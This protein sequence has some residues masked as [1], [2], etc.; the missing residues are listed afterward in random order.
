MQG[1][2]DLVH[3]Q[4]ALLRAR[5][6]LRK[7][8]PGELIRPTSPS[9]L[10]GAPPAPAVVARLDRIAVSVRRAS[11]YG[12]FRPTCLVRAIALED[13]AHRTGIDDSVVRVGVR[14]HSGVFEAHAWLELQGLVV[15]DTAD[16]VA[17]FT[18]LE[19]FSSLVGSER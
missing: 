13:L 7:R 4:R 8:A 9:A 15:G 16:N 3:G 2:V 10:P 14:R 11:D 17:R 6:A 18:V 1:A 19:D 5:R 12:L